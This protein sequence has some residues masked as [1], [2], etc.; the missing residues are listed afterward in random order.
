MSRYRYGADEAS[1]FEDDYRGFDI[2]DDETARGP[3]I[4]ALAIGVLLVFGAVVWNTYRQGVRSNGGGLPSVI[5]DAQP[6]KRI[7]DE[8]GG[9]EVRDTDK[10]FYDQ[11]DASERI[12]DLAS[13]DGG[14]GS[15]MLQGGPPIDLRPTDDEVDG[16]D[17]DNGMPNSV[18]DEVAELA[19]LS[20]PDRGID[21]EAPAPMPAP[22]APLPPPRE[23]SPSSP[24]AKGASTSCRWQ[25]FAPRMLQR[26]HGANLRLSTRISTAVPENGSSGPIWAPKVCST[27]CESAALAKKQRQTPFA[28]R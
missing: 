17:P 25:R 7:P 24:S 26:P 15:D 21:S 4:L 10:R 6:Y 22:R 2:R 19:D 20:R 8:R 5:A 27:A 14:D 18:A 3:L 28:M 16:S 9:L 23:V 11:M 12:P 1:P 13:L